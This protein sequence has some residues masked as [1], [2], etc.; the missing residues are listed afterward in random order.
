MSTEAKVGLVFFLGL[1]LVLWFTIYVGDITFEQGQYAVRFPNVQGIT[2]GSQ[3]HY[4]GV[5]IGQVRRVV[6]VV[7]EAG[8]AMVEVYFDVEEERRHAVRI[9]PDTRFTINQGFLGSSTL[10]IVTRGKGDMISQEVLQGREGEIP[11]TMSDVLHEIHAMVAENRANLSRGVAGLPEAIESFRTMSD[12][13][14]ELVL[15][16]RDRLRQAIVHISGMGKAIKELVEANKDKVAAAIARI[17]GMSTQVEEVIKENR[18]DVRSTVARLP[19][20]VENI[21]GAAG[22]IRSMVEENRKDLAATMGQLAAFAPKLNAIGLDLKRI[23]SQIASGRGT[24]GKLVMEDTLHDKATT[25]IDAVNQRMEEIEPMTAGIGQLKFYIGGYGGI[26]TDT[27]ALLGTIYLRIE[28]KPWK[29][30]EAGATYRGAPDDR[31]VTEEDPEDLNIDINIMLGW[32]FFPVDEYQQYRVSVK[33][34]LI[35]GAVGGQVDMPVWRDRLFAHAMIRDRHNEY[36]RD[37]RRYEAGSGPYARATL[38]WRVWRRVS[39]HAGGDDLF[40]EPAPFLAVSA[41]L[42]DNDI[43]NLVTAAGIIP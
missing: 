8:R 10:E 35:E 3:V 27:G 18:A 41:E 5:K 14:R 34:G 25:A 33:G 30:Y 39:I 31:E 15:T 1:G 40:N 28:P 32:R 4:N 12:Q 23:T 13:V 17:E 9:N 26:N 38:E 21:S 42:L 22:S 7:S 36:D 16:N 37:D 24:V 43:R 6:P 11:V 19:K 20:T 2:I 29:F